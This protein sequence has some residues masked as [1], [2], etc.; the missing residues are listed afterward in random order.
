MS[1]FIGWLFA[2]LFGIGYA[3]ARL[4]IFC[5]RKQITAIEDTVRC[6]ARQGYDDPHAF[7]QSLKRILE[8][9]Y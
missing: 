8:G 2:I 4:R 7:S 1:T 5:Y 6:N 3:I 9:E